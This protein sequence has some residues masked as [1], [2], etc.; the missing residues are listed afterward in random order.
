MDLAPR[1]SKAVIMMIDNSI[2][3]IDADFHPTRLQAQKQTV[4]RYAEYLLS[5]D[6]CSVIAVGTL[7]SVE[8]GIHL[9]FTNEIPKMTSVISHISAG[10]DALLQKG[11]KTAL[12]ALRHCSSDIPS[13]KIVAF[14]SSK[15][16]LDEA[17]LVQFAAAIEQVKIGCELVIIG[18]DVPNEALVLRALSPEGP[19]GKWI[20]PLVVH[21]CETVLSDRVLSSFIGPETRMSRVELSEYEKRDPKLAEAIDMSVQK[22]VVRKRRQS[23]LENILVSNTRQRARQPRVTKARKRNEKDQKP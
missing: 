12:L 3:S 16:D 6:P 14:V 18:P 15:N 20:R 23:S 5:A 1:P 17:F 9:S 19:A 11:L 2:S 8:F 4:E 22:S 10:G 7:S 21:Q 13:R